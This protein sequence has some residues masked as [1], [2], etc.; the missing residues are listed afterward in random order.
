[1]RSSRLPR[2]LTPTPLALAVAAHR[3]SARPLIDLTETN[4]TRAGFAYPRGLLQPLADAAAL[5][6]DP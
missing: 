3:A 2:N 1:M 5:R 4:P 6:Y